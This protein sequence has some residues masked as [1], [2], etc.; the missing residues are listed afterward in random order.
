MSVAGPGQTLLSRQATQMLDPAALRT[1][2]HGHWRLKGLAEPVELFEI[3]DEAEP[4][5]PPV[6]NPKAYRVVRD[7][8]LWLPVRQIRHSLPAERDAFVDRRDAIDELVRRF[9]AGARLISL[10]GIG[11]TGK[12]RLATR[13]AWDWLGEFP[14]GAWFCDLA[15]ARGID[16]IASAVGLALDVPLGKEDAVTQLGHAIAGRGAC[17]MILDNFEQVARHAEATLGK[18]LDRAREARFLVTSVGVLGIPGESV[19][20]LSPLPLD[21]AAILF[22][23]RARFAKRGFEPRGED[24]DAIAPLV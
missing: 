5:R 1:Q 11:G 15:Q 2:S 14:G 17:L 19:L 24:M 7:G 16:G 10:T 3:A 20:P 22:T 23:Q 13:L 6:E 4:P 12:T 18:W 21:Y 8:E 9:D